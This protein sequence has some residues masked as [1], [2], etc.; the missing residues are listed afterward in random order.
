[1]ATQP[2]EYL[3]WIRIRQIYSKSRY[4]VCRSY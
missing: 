3:G 2:M 1:M 4:W